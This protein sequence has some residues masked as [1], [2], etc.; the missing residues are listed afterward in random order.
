[1]ANGSNPLTQRVESYI[2]F[3][4]RY[5]AA[6][7]DVLRAECGLTPDRVVADVGCGTGL[8]AE[9]FLTNRNPVYGVEPDADMRAGAGWYLQDYPAFTAVEGSAEA[10]GLPDASV[11]FVTV[12]QAFHWFDIPST[13]AEFA[14]ILRPGGWVVIVWNIQQAAGT[15]FLGALQRF[16]ADDRYDRDPGANDTTKVERSQAYRLDPALV[17]RELLDPFFGVGGYRE[18]HFDNPL[19]CDYEGLKGR[20]LSNALALRPGDEGYDDMLDALRTIFDA[21]QV[22]GTVTIAH[23]TRLVYG[24]LDG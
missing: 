3:R 9:L 8:L 17:D 12:G 7:L 20:V 16:W 6:A 18:A 11:D 21:Y 2:R 1:M 5:P 22:D 24:H 15:P 10:T 19:P 14:R 13:R 23:D 4:P